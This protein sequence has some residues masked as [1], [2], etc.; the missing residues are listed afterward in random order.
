VHNTGSCRTKQAAPC[1]CCFLAGVS[2]TISLARRAACSTIPHRALLIKNTKGFVCYLFFNNRRQCSGRKQIVICLPL[3]RHL[4]RA[5]WVLSSS[6][7][8]RTVPWFRASP[9]EVSTPRQP[10]DAA[11]KPTRRHRPGSN[12]SVSPAEVGL[13]RKEAKKQSRFAC[14]SVSRKARITKAAPPRLPH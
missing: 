5:I 2:A 7:R 10:A 1:S 13:R 11:G 8:M 3:A 6:L 4:A 9:G 12:G 14:K